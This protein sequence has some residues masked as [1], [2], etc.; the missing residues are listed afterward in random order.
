M[1][2]SP[3]AVIIDLWCNSSIAVSKTADKSAN[4]LGPVGDISLI[5]KASA[6]NTDSNREIGVW[7]Q[8]LLSP[9]VD[10][11]HYKKLNYKNDK[12][13]NKSYGKF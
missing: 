5:G 12:K 9:L 3:V 1:G 13:G 8:V 11:N 4:L 10:I 7:V 6:L 2:S